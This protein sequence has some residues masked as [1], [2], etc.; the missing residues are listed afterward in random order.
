MIK[1]NYILPSR[2]IAKEDKFYNDHQR[3]ATSANSYVADSANGKLER[4]IFEV[5]G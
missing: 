2:R 1:V 4:T 5:L 3:S